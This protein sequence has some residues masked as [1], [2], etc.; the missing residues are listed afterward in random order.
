MISSR[1]QRSWWFLTLS[2]LSKRPSLPS[3]ITVWELPL[4]GIQ[5]NRC[6]SVARLNFALPNIFYFRN[7]SVCW[8]LLISFVFC[9]S[10]TKMLLLKLKSWRNTSL[11]PGEV[12]MHFLKSCDGWRNL[13]LPI[14]D[15]LDGVKDLVSIGPDASLF[16]AIC[17]LL[18]NRIHRLPVIDT[19]TGNVLYIITHKRLLRFLFLYVSKGTS[20]EQV[21][22]ANIIWIFFQISDLPRPKYFCESIYNLVSFWIYSQKLVIIIGYY[23]PECLGNWYLWQYW[24]GPPFNANHWRLRKICEQKNFSFANC[25]RR[26][27]T[28]WYLCKVWRDCRFEGIG[29]DWKMD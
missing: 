13:L 24:S 20:N 26:R 19:E 15:V 28:S 10:I 3:S 29:L 18:H 25:G 1:L 8:P 12:W 16:D 17:V 2:F 14:L 7:L 11:K 4:F 23:Y 9:T 21:A 22:N 27:K 6:R 5:R